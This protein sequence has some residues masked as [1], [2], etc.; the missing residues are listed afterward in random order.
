MPDPESQ[1]WQVR[2]D[3]FEFKRDPEN[4]CLIGPD[5]CHYDTEAEAMYFDQLGLCGCGCPSE[6]HKFLVEA[7][8]AFDREGK[9][10][11]G[12]GVDLIKELI[13]SNPDAVAEFVA[14]FLNNRALL[15]HGAN[16]YGAWLTERGKQFVEIG[17][18]G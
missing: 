10:W 11:E 3:R 12:A 17:A 16:V 15:E 18:H 2:Q 4:G 14:H 13:K 5:G 7:A 8:K 9:G 6:V 1:D